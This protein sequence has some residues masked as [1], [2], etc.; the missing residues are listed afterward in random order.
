MKKRSVQ[1]TQAV[2][3]FAVLS[4]TSSLHAEDF[5]DLSPIINNFNSSY[6]GKEVVIP[7]YSR[8][9]SDNNG[10]DDKFS[11]K[12]NVFKNNT[13]GTSGLAYSTV[14]K[15]G[16]FP[17]VSCGGAI[18]YHDFDQEPKFLR[19][20]NIVIVGN[21]VSMECS[22]TAQPTENYISNAFIYMTDVS[23]PGKTA[24]TFSVANWDLSGMNLLDYNNDGVNDLVISLSLANNI[25]IIAINLKSTSPFNT[26]NR[27]SDKTYTT[28]VK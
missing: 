18:N 15:Y 28:F 9:D 3:T 7:E 1:Y 11:L 22:G 5:T 6:A 8:Y 27:I 23:A 14:K 21:K 13:S 17:T 19:S 12:L 24:Y 2:M 16:P 10:I 26:A 4:L 20:G 25:R